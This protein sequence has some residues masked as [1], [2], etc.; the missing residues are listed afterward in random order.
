MRRCR[1]VPVVATLVSHGRQA[2]PAAAGSRSALTASAFLACLQHC[3]VLQLLYCHYSLP[4]LHCN[5]LY[6]TLLSHCHHTFA[7]FQAAGDTI[8]F[9]V[10]SLAEYNS[11]M[12]IENLIVI[13][14]YSDRESETIKNTAVCFICYPTQTSYPRYFPYTDKNIILQNSLVPQRCKLCC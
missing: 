12:W 11:V 9:N 14:Y 13:Q 5:L 10:H 8:P 4:C 1:L 6:L 7:P 2:K 3:T